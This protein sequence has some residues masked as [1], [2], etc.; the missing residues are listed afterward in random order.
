MNLS[1]QTLLPVSSTGIHGDDIRSLAYVVYATVCG[2]L[3]LSESVALQ[4]Q[5]TVQKL[6][7]LLCPL[8]LLAACNALLHLD[9]EWVLWAR[10]FAREQHVYHLRRLFQLPLVLLA[11]LLLASG[12]Q[13]LHRI[14][15][16]F[17]LQTLVLAGACGT[18]VLHLLRFVSFHYTDLALNLILLDHSVSS[19]IECASL[20][21]VASGTGLELLRSRGHV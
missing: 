19:W 5:H 10:A 15:S 12:W 3:G 1:L 14:R 9:A 13:S 8:Y 11:F 2:Y 20:G 6:W 7:L 4:T 16:T 18:L 17:A 21:L